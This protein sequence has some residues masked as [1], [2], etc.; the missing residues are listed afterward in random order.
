MSS[1]ALYDTDAYA[2]EVEAVITDLGE[3]DGRPFAV[4]DRTLLYPEG[5]GQPADRGWLNAVTVVDVQRVDG[6]IRHFMDIDAP[7]LD[8]LGAGPVQVRVDWE[9]RFDHMQQ[10]T[11]QHLLTAVAAD[12][13]GWPTRAFHLG[14][15]VSDIELD[16]PGLDVRALAALEDAVM[17]EVRGA[18]S[19]FARWVER[20]VLQRTAVRTRGLPKGH[21]GPVRLVEI[22][23]VDVNTC[24]GTHVRSTAEIE[25]I[26]LLA[27]EPM[28]GGTRLHFVA[29]GRVRHHLGRHVARTA[30]LRQ[31]LGVPDD[32]LPAAVADRLTRLAAR[33]REIRGLVVDL[34][35]ATAMALVRAPDTIATLHATNRDMAFLQAVARAVHAADPR[36]SA[37]LTA[38]EPGGD[39]EGAGVFVWVV[40]DGATAAAG[41]DVAAIAGD[42]AALLE[43]RGGGT[44]PFFQGKATRLD[45]RHEAAAMLGAAQGSVG[46]TSEV[47]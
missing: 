41:G 24:G 38:S 23:G 16:V 15:D 9:R 14:A 12:R 8:D 39:G 10:H 3:A 42:L 1:A 45:R 40:G 6:E 20:D 36:R 27:V 32:A 43:G 7:E 18:R 44:P 31:I 22:T 21:A 47:R 28:R 34:A 17:A 2:T 33:E 11:A 5:G 25:S 37:L 13:F 46:A 30:A 19:V 4:L 29:G 35:E 26:K